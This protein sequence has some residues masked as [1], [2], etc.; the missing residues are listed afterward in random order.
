VSSS[1]STLSSTKKSNETLPQTGENN[2]N[3]FSYLGL[4]ALLGAIG[5]TKG[6]KKKED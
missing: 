3:E 5:L 6:K 2:N 1:E 4:A